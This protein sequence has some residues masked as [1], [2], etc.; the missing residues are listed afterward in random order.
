MARVGEQFSRELAVDETE[1]VEFARATGDANPLHVDPAYA[2][3]TR[4]TRIVACP[5]WYTSRLKALA[6]TEL[7]R[8]GPCVVLEFSF[9]FL[10]P[11]LAGD[12]IR[13]A[14]QVVDVMRT[15]RLDGEMVSLAGKI[16]NQLDKVVLMGHAKVLL[17]D[18]L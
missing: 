7:S 3:T 12:R 9:S 13:L 14:W 8:E 1:V 2:A 17:T 10:R 6:S 4:Y 18:K 16:T 15:Q 11:V 5:A